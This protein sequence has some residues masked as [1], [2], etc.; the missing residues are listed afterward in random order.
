MKD[1]AIYGAGGFG[2]E[3]ACLIQAINEVNS[4]WNLIG[5]FDDTHEKGTMNEYGEILGGMNDLNA[6]DKEIALV[7]AIG[8]PNALEK[9]SSSIVNS[10]VYY[11]NII[12]PDVVF[13]DKS[14][15]KMGKGNII[16]FHSIISCST[17]IGDFNLM[18]NDVMIGHDALIGNFNVFNPSVRVSGNVK[19]GNTNFFGVCS[20]VLQ[21]LTIGCDTK[22][23]ANSCVMRNTRDKGLYIGTP[24]IMRLTPEI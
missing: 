16:L 10:N 11:P 21:K 12:A 5:F 6:Y 19:I 2:R 17:Q 4:E 8:S 1:I 23:A 13:H 9:L 18:N 7:I 14:S 20:V 15:V 24:A 3:A 22:I